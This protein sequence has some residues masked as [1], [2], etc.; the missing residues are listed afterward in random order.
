MALC[1][2]IFVQTKTDRCHAYVIHSA[3]L[4]FPFMSSRLVSIYWQI[5]PY[6]YVSSYL[7]SQP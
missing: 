5:A 3:M 6:S 7:A 2:C 4:L 1:M